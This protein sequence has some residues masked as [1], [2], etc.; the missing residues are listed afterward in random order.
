MPFQK[1][2]KIITILKTYDTFN[3]NRNCNI[4]IVTQAYPDMRTCLLLGM[5]IAYLQ[6]WILKRPL[7]R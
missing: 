5:F 7:G 3:H 6:N 2:E 1:R 4:D